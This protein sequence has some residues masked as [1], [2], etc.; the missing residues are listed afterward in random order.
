M[1]ENLPVEKPPDKTQLQSSVVS[2]PTLSKSQAINLCAV[3]LLICFFLPWV[4]LLDQPFSG[5][6]LQ[7]LGGI[8]LAFWLIPV[9]CITTIV[10]GLIKQSQK[11]GALLTGSLPFFALAYWYY[12]LGP[13]LLKILTIGAYVGLGLALA[14]IVLST[15]LK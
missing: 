9:F 10:A 3:G 1:S 7:K 13:D 11:S 15:K 8:Y 5:F 14:L 12:Q 6:T 2:A 4:Y